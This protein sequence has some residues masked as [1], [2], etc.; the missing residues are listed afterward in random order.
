MGNRQRAK[1]GRRRGRVPSTQYPVPST[2][3]RVPSTG[4]WV[5]STGYW[6][7]GTGNWV[8]GTRPWP[9]SVGLGVA[10]QPGRIDGH[11]RVVR[12]ERVLALAALQV[13]KQG[14]QRPDARP[15]RRHVELVHPTVPDGLDQHV[16]AD[17]HAQAV[18]VRVERVVAG[19]QVRRDRPARRQVPG[20][21]VVARV[22]AAEGEP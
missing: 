4:Y 11:R 17:A 9:G 19:P 15:L 13:D 20:G 10:E 21:R 12:G 6:V 14:R 22:I 2:E 8:L 3:Y 16:H 18:Q 5:L 1:R 7:L